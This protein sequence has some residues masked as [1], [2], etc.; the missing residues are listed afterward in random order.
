MLGSIVLAG[1]KKVSS[2]VWDAAKKRTGNIKLAKL[3]P[4]KHKLDEPHKE[5]SI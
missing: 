4:F 3:N 5:E 1:S 2:A